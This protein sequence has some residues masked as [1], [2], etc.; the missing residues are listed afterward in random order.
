MLGLK[1]GLGIIGAGNMSSAIIKGV[2]RR[3]IFQPE[4]IQ[5]FDIDS[6]KLKNLTNQ[7]QVKMAQNN[8]E[9]VNNSSIIIIAVKPT[10]YSTVLEEIKDALSKGQILISIAAGISI[11]YI[12]DTIDN[13]CKVVR[14]MPNT[15]AL[16]GESMTALCTEHDLNKDEQQMIMKILTS[17]GAVEEISEKDINAATAISGSSPAYVYLFIEA[18]SDGGVMMGLSREQSYRMAAQAVL[19]AAKMMLESNKHPGV[20]KDEVCSPAGT[21]IEAVY[22]LEKNAFRGALMEA[23]RN[24]AL[25]AE[26]IS[27]NR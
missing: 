22:T 4:Q 12:K 10:A 8:G 19:G 14:I 2:L 21:T 23:V 20:L 3:E 15:P 11:E 13:R 18:L 27:K 16:I 7:T 25:K 17:L 5:V 24:C 9:L 1:G 6:S 26:D